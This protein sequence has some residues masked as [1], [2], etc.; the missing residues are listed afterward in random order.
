[1]WWELESMFGKLS[2]VMWGPT[3]W[4]IV[5]SFLGTIVGVLIL[6]LKIRREIRR[7]VHL[8]IVLFGAMAMLSNFIYGGVTRGFLGSAV[9][10][11]HSLIWQLTLAV[12]ASSSLAY[13]T[14]VVRLSI[15]GT[16]IMGGNRDPALYERH[17]RIGYWALFFLFITA[18]L[19]LPL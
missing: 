1:M 12:H 18:L 4:A 8:V 14:N 3:K 17:R 5:I 11:K 2:P 13:F 6:K 15:L 10:T 9:S 7:R 19:A 16:K